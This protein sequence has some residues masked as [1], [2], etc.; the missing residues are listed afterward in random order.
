MSEYVLTFKQ[1]SQG[2]GMFAGLMGH[3]R[4]S[5]DYGD[6]RQSMGDQEGKTGM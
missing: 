6:R 2:Q 3:K 1:S 5:E 4:G